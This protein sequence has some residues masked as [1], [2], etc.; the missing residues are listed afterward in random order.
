M[1]LN[2]AT[3]Y[4]E[5]LVR[6]L[7]CNSYTLNQINNVK[8]K[9]PNP[10]NNNLLLE[11]KNSLENFKDVSSLEIIYIIFNDI[12]NEGTNYTVN[13]RELVLFY[14]LSRDG[15]MKKACEELK[16]KY[17]GSRRSADSPR[18]VYK[19]L[20]LELK[21]RNYS[22]DQI[23]QVRKEF[24]N[25]KD[26]DLLSE[27][28]YNIN[29][30]V[31][32]SVYDITYIYFQLVKNS[33]KE[34][35]HYSC[36]EI[37]SV[38]YEVS[39]NGSL[40]DT[41]KSLSETQFDERTP[42]AL[43]SLYDRTMAA[44]DDKLYTEDQLQFVKNNFKDSTPD[45]ILKDIE[46]KKESLQDL[47]TLDVVYLFFTKLRIESIK[48]TADNDN[49]EELVLLYGLNRSVS[50]LKA[51]NKL[52][53]DY[54]LSRNDG[55]LVNCFKGLNKKFKNKTYSTDQVSKVKKVFEN[56]GSDN[57]IEEIKSKIKEFNGLSII[58]IIYIKYQKPL[59]WRPVYETK[60]RI[61][62]GAGSKSNKKRKTST[63]YDCNESG[64]LR[65]S[66]RLADQRNSKSLKRSRTDDVD[67]D[68][69]ADEEV[70]VVVDEEEEGEDDDVDEEEEEEVGDVNVDDEDYA[71][72]SGDDL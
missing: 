11:I 10:N 36:H 13:E 45:T 17:F 63:N 24:E 57:V 21:E 65:R 61:E 43:K 47:D 8:N 56:L 22:S 42:K 12:V 71:G 14:C 69:V 59:N 3:E 70:D 16:S 54:S 23:E 64:G 7:S 28:R 27:F 18:T 9:F 66:S 35:R 15:S 34:N 58:D 5:D 37:L 50:V 49:E 48:N 33:S 26:A 53:S 20:M 25:I 2:S 62:S 4:V 55:D 39:K 30:F 19:R 44:L 68:V 67:E 38:V 60:K 1:D 51:M 32:L 52:K 72:D 46:S 29:K 41:F 6:R 40:P 31:N